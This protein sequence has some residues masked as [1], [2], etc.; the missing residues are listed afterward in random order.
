MC[1]RI[2]EQFPSLSLWYLVG[3]QII[4]LGGASSKNK[5]IIYDREYDGISSFFKMHQPQYQTVIKYLL[6][7]NRFLQLH[8]Y[9]YLKHVS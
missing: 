8:V 6:S 1:Y 3:P 4:H 7:I 5:Q 2:H 9:K